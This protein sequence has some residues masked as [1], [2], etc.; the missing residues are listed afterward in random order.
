[1]LAVWSASRDPA[2]EQRLRDRFGEAEILETPHVR[3]QPDVV[4]VAR[5][6]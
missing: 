5:V 2:F 3:A 1:V 4:Y 6:A